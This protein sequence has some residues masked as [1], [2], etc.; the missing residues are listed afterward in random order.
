M[1]PPHSWTE[2]EHDLIRSR[3]PRASWDDI[4]RELKLSRWCVIDHARRIGLWTEDKKPVAA[5]AEWDRSWEPPEPLRP[6]HPESWGCI[7]RGTM[8]EGAAYA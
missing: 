2:S 4:A 8:L 3:R 7:V 1:P 5:R 6:G